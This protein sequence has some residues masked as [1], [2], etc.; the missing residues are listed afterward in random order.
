LLRVE[1]WAFCCGQNWGF[2]FSGQCK[3]YTGNCL[4]RKLSPLIPSQTEKKAAEKVEVVVEELM[5]I[6][7]E[8]PC[9][10]VSGRVEREEEEAEGFCFA[11]EDSSKHDYLIVREE[12]EL[13]ER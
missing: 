5:R 13:D 2:N 3:T 7:K 4:H 12:A 10:T 11:C 9:Q 8:K 6:V 1:G